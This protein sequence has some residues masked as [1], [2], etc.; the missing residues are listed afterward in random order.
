MNWKING[1]TFAARDLANV[2]LELANMAT[3]R[4]TFEAPGRD[5]TA[6]SL[7]SYDQ[8]VSITRDDKPYF[9]GRFGRIPVHGDDKGEGHSFE[10]LGPWDQLERLTYMQRWKSGHWEGDVYVSDWSFK[11]RCVLGQDETGQ[12]IPVGG[13]ISSVIDYAIS[14]GIQFQ[15]GIIDNGPLLPWS[16][17][18]DMSC[19]D[20]IRKL[21]RWIPDA[22]GYF[23]YGLAIPVFHFRVR[24]SLPS[25]TLSIGE[26]IV[27]ETLT[28][29]GSRSVPAVVL[30][31]EQSIDS[32][33]V[34]MMSTVQDVYPS[35]AT[36]RE[37]GAIVQTIALP[38]WSS[39]TT[40]Q[41]QHVHC[42]LIPDFDGNEGAFLVW[43][44][45]HHPEWAS[46]GVPGAFDAS[47]FRH[48][49]INSV[50]RTSAYYWELI[51]GTLQDWMRRYILDANGNLVSNPS[52][53]YNFDDS[54]DNVLV[55]IS[56]QAINADGKVM[57]EVQ[58]KVITTKI[59]ATN[60]PPGTYKNVSSQI[61]P[62]DQ[63][64]VGLARYIFDSLNARHFQG[65]V[66]IAEEEVTGIVGV[67]C[68]LL[69]RGGRPE[70]GDMSAIVQSIQSNLDNGIT[71]IRVGPP[72][73]LSVND[74]LELRRANRGRRNCDDASARISGEIT[75]NTVEL[76]SAIPKGFGASSAGSWGVPLDQVI[77]AVRFDPV[78]NSL[79]VKFRPVVVDYAETE[80]DWTV[81]DGGQ[82]ED[83]NASQV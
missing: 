45:N 34:T 1:N 61:S 65:S 74:V 48:V 14:C 44:L 40:V 56:Y 35:T 60:C 37:I 33:G 20:V 80:S 38:G 70:W 36:G 62:G 66:V 79:Q 7:F 68:R 78:S 19:A 2:S 55:T 3:D 72:N 27:S 26:N 9:C 5:I 15:K 10:I 52:N 82:A 67:G 18:L 64:Q 76:G 58:N 77:T 50:T 54:E 47:K 29:V 59:I 32:N 73:H 41:K 25:K 30:I 42:H 12:S 23:D 6:D 22:V 17:V 75:R 46:P 4:M 49:T 81:I 51:E 71:T 63:I 31:Y 57:R 69:I 13:I 83:C 53:K 8:P 28:A 21:S 39:T 16:E 11:S 43:F 24:S